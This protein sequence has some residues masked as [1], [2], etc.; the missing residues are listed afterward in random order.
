MDVR[1]MIIVLL[2]LCFIIKNRNKHFIGF[3]IVAL[4]YGI[5]GI[6]FDIVNSFM[7]FNG[8]DRIGVM[9]YINLVIQIIPIFSILFLVKKLDDDTK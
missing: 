8:N 5:F 4:S 1:Y 6:S 2:S 7:S 3:N 9:A